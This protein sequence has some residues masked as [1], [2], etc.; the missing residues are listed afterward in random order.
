MTR[1]FHRYQ[2]FDLVT[3]TLK[4]DLL[5][6]NFNIGNDFL[7]RRG[8]AFIFHICIS[9]SKIFNAEPWF[10]TLKID[11]LFKK[12]DRDY[13]FWIRGVTYCCYLYMVVAGELCG[14]SENSGS[15]CLN[16]TDDLPGLRFL[17][18]S[19]CDNMD[20]FCMSVLKVIAPTLEFLDISGC[21]GI[22]HH[23]LA[24]LHHLE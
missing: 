19:Y 18:L 23:G 5:L 12:I 15:I 7:K 22:T 2:N 14:L 11:L 9:C 3:L 1:P 10:L 13:D 6:K 16:I 17:D 21:K 20:D 8:R 4:F 24:C